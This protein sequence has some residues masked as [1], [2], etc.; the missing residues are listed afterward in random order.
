MQSF[1]LIHGD[2]LKELP[3]IPDRSIDCVISDPPYSQD[4]KKHWDKIIPFE[5]LWKELKRIIK[6]EGAILLTGQQPFTSD[7]VNSNKQWFRYELIWDKHIPRGRHQAKVQPMRKHEN[8]IVFSKH[9]KHNYYPRTIRG[10][11]NPTSIIAAGSVAGIRPVFE[12]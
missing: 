7:L 8:I 5:P 3:K 6:D 9:A 4:H 1:Q 10:D 11:K 2:C 12:W